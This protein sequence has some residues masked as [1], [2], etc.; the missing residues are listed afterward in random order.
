[1]PISDDSLMDVVVDLN[2]DESSGDE[3]DSDTDAA[4][5]ASPGNAKAQ[6]ASPGPPPRRPS[7]PSKLSVPTMQSMRR[8]M[9]SPSSPQGNSLL[10]A[11][12]AR[13]AKSRNRSAL[14]KPATVPVH[15][16]SAPMHV[17]AQEVVA[18]IDK[19]EE[20]VEPL[21][22]APTPS[23]AAATA[24]AAAA[25]ST[26]L[27]GG[28][29]LTVTP[30]TFKPGVAFEMGGVFGQSSPQGDALLARKLARA[31]QRKGK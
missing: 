14:S 24:A 20:D 27:S 3:S 23:T 25:A 13:A 22:T 1:M 19:A 17:G 21:A 5:A 10:R 30:S 2:S 6:A 8:P 31:S 12:A 26:A 15:D 28:P 29:R 9:G 7:A 4:D 16:D 18:H 11:K